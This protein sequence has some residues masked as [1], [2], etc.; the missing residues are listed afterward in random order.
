MNL[1]IIFSSIIF[2]GAILYSQSD[3]PAPSKDTL[4]YADTVWSE[5][6]PECINFN[7]I[8]KLVRYPE[9][10]RE[11]NIEGRVLIK[12]LVDT[13]GNVEK[14]GE[15]TGPAEFYIEVQRVAMFLKFNPVIINNSRVKIW[16]PVP[17][18]F[19]LK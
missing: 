15:I 17:F 3:I 7:E 4:S 19:K 12:C 1:R 11:N 6:A 14:T 13:N 16:V 8:S 9:K 2:T 5:N 18:S 10:A